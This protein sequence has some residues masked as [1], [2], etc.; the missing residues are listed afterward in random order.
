MLACLELVKDSSVSSYF[1]ENY[2]GAW[3]W[4]FFKNKNLQ[5]N[6][7]E[8][9]WNI[10]SHNYP[11][12]YGTPA[13]D[14]AKHKNTPIT[15]LKILYELDNEEPLRKAIALHTNLDEELTMKFLNSNIKSE[16]LALAK[17]KYVDLKVLKQLSNDNDEDVQ[18]WA[19][20]NIKKRSD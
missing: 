3:E 4:P 9:L 15:V 2:F 17:S 1:D 10:C 14:V 19:L 13:R 12:A 6:D 5:P 11:I 7:I 20:E 16:R 8:M 18:F